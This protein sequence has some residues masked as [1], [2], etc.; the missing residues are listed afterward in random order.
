MTGGLVQFARNVIRSAGFDV[1]HR[2]DEHLPR[3]LLRARETLRVAPHLRAAER[4]ELL[5]GIAREGHLAS[6]LHELAIDTVVDVGANRGQFI[7]TL[8][9]LGYRR[10]IVAFEPHAASFAAV[11]ELAQSDP[12]LEVHHLA[13]GD[14]DGALPL[15]VTQ[16]TRFSSL[17]QPNTAARIR[18]GEMVACDH[19]ETVPV[20]TLDGLTA[21]LLQLPPNARILLKSDTQGHD[22]AVL[23]GASTLLARALAVTTEASVIPLY[24]QTPAYDEVFQFLREHGFAPS[25]LYPI[26]HD[27]DLRLIE[28]D[29]FFVRVA[30]SSA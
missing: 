6:L 22:L 19:V 15:H 3:M 25:G 8:R 12:Q 16:D 14:A 20:R 4:D 13:L 2:S 26:A 28:L 21:T 17:H 27:T 23:R 7:T 30:S 18:F 29:C 24:T 9:Q 1:I 11:T 5:A 10:R